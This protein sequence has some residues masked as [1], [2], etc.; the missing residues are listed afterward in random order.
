MKT[1]AVPL[2]KKTA[3]EDHSRSPDGGGH[4]AGIPATP[5]ARKG[6][7]HAAALTNSLSCGLE[8]CANRAGLVDADI[9]LA[10]GNPAK[11]ILSAAQLL[12]SDLII[13]GTH[14]TSGFVHLVLGSVTEKVLRQAPCPVLTIPPRAHRVATRSIACSLDRRPTRSFGGRHV[15]C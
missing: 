4:G 14:G 5:D 15:R 11:Q 6:T 7:R 13:M 8:G 3:A 9:V 12:P 1:S 2:R 10:H